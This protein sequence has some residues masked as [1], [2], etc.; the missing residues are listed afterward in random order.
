MQELGKAMAALGA[1]G[2]SPERIM[3]AVR[4]FAE[5]AEGEGA[6]PEL[7]SLLAELE[8]GN[9]AGATIERIQEKFMQ[10][11]LGSA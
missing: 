5:S 8:A 4:G 9:N 10:R 11:T 2:S 7:Q 1:M 3:E 6:D